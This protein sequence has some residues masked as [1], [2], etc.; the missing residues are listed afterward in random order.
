[1]I[2]GRAL[3]DGA[4]MALAEAALALTDDGVARGDGAFE[5]VGVWG[6]RPFRLDDHL[7]RLA[8]SLAAIGLPPPDRPLLAAEA[9]GLLGELGQADAALRFYLTASGT[10]VVTLGPQ[11]VRPAAR[12]LVAQPA[13]WIQ[14][15]GT[16]GPAGAKS[17]SYGPNMTATRAARR[18][19][20][21]DAL[22][23]SLE[24]FVLEGPTLGVLW[25]DGDVVRA[26]SLDLGIV[27]SIS[28]ATVL[29]AA[30]DAG[31]EVQ[32]G[33]YRLDDLRGAA[34]FLIC[35]ALRP[36]LAIE[37]VGDVPFPGG[38][39]GELLGKSL[40]AARRSR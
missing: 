14:P 36:V 10:R 13:P 15:L 12:V 3:I 19:G 11:P 16:Y 21:D 25:V 27:D 23:V 30:L 40:E 8:R 7:D 26:P 35:S 6:G 29:Q 2:D 22:L 31:L 17:M 18:A 9:A 34:E 24:G 5:A 37:R 1:M 4:P 33:H 20:G 32:Q 28:R 38:D 39:V